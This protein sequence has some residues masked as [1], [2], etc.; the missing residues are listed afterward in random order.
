L[1]TL[2]GAC[3]RNTNEQSKKLDKKR[4]DVATTPPPRVFTTRYLHWEARGECTAVGFNVVSSEI[5]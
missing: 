4:E 3:L 1:I 2:L 5:P